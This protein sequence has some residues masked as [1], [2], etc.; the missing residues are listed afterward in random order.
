M[1]SRDLA[2]GEDQWLGELRVRFAE[3][4][5]PEAAGGGRYGELLVHL[6][7]ETRSLAVPAQPPAELDAGGYRFGDFLRV[8]IPLNLTMGLLSSFL[9]PLLWPL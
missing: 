3:E 5:L 9:I 6:D 1:E 7:G 4:G 8:G 2:L